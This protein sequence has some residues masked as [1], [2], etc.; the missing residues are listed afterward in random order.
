M[1]KFIIN[2]QVI[3]TGT[4]ALQT[5]QYVSEAIGVGLGLA[6]MFDDGLNPNHIVSD[7]GLG[8]SCRHKLTTKAP[9]YHFVSLVSIGKVDSLGQ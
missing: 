2:F 9:S 5:A 3:W 8:R 6:E 4:Y 7:E 1:R